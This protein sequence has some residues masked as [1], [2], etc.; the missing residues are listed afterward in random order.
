MRTVVWKPFM[1][2]L[3]PINGFDRGK[4]PTFRDALKR[5]RQLRENGQGLRQAAQVLAEEVEDEL[6]GSIEGSKNFA[7]NCIS[8]FWNDSL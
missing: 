7:I 1:G 2:D 5:L 4:I 6:P 3:E 8:N